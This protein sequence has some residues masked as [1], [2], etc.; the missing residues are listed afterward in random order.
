MVKK[1]YSSKWNSSSQVRKQRK[2]RHN[3]PLHQKQKF[4]H[5][6][7]SAELRKKYAGRAIQVRT[8]DKIKVVQGSFRKKEGKVERIDLKREH[9]FVSGIE[10]IKKD[11]T[12]LIAPLVPSNLMIIELDLSD[13]KRKE[14]LEE[15]KKKAGPMEKKQ[16]VKPE[17]KR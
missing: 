14:K 7:L 4:M 5:V 8:G 10:V 17:D 2:F 11:G 16:E 1:D 15:K 13:K 3:A 9:V 12:K 6:H